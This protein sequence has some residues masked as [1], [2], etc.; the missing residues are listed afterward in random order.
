M[1]LL[2]W[3]QQTVDD[4]AA[5]PQLAEE[6]GEM[7]APSNWIG[8]YLRTTGGRIRKEE[9][10]KPNKQKQIKH[11][12]I[13][14]AAAKCGLQE[15]AVWNA[16]VAQGRVRTQQVTSLIGGSEHTAVL[17]PHIAAAMLWMFKVTA[18]EKL[19]MT[20]E[21]LGRRRG[22]ATLCDWVNEAASTSSVQCFDCWRDEQS[23]HF[24][25]GVQFYFY[26]FFF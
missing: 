10:K 3:C 26:L 13:C 15:T 8:C 12:R 17:Q 22:F 11:W 2:P 23:K 18:A 4:A 19:L 20:D 25:V 24:D 21:P 6:P 7:N 1:N 16:D 5:P 9:K 14:V